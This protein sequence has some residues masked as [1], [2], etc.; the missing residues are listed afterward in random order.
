MF[1]KISEQLGFTEQEIKVI[2]FLLTT[3]SIGFGYKLI[4]EP[5]ADFTLKVFDYSLQDSLFASAGIT[6]VDVNIQPPQIEL[7]DKKVDY[8]QEVLDFNARNFEKSEPKKIPAEK[9]IN[10][11]KAGIDELMMLPGIGIKTAELILEYRKIN[12]NFK[13]LEDIKNVKG[14]GPAKFGKILKYIFIE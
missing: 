8:K 5:D 14:I 4:T 2:V 3:L 12:G 9:S 11:N 7:T 10:L 6:H 1:R 13:K